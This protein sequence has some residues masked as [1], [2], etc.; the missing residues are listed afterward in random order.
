MNMYV[1][2]HTHT[3]KNS[4]IHPYIHPS[5][6]MYAE[7]AYACTESISSLKIYLQVP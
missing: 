6:L 1:Y 7:D 5:I 4:S 2:V 3:H